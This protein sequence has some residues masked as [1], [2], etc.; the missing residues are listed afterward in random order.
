MYL[1][2]IA[3]A[4]FIPFMM[5]GQD[6]INIVSYNIRLDHEGDGKDQWKF[7]KEG[8]ASFLLEENADFIGLQEVLHHQLQ[9]LDSMLQGYTFIGVARDDGK[10][11]GEY[12]PLF[13]NNLEWR[14]IRQATNW[15]S[16]KPMEVSRGWDAACNRVVTYGVFEHLVSGEQ[17]TV[18]NT[19][20]DHMGVE[21]RK[22]S[23]ALVVEWAA[24]LSGSKYKVF[25]G[26]F[27]FTP[28]DEL[29]K[30]ITNK[31]FDAR[32]KAAVKEEVHPGTYNGFALT[33][34]YPR[35]IDYVFINEGLKPVK[36]Y[37]P[38]IRIDGRHISDH[39]PVIVELQY[40]E[41]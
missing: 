19:H 24:S 37:C 27:N 7:R 6:A 21:A 25:T 38:D 22:K 4:L 9:Y 10:T 40:K 31:L 13:Y 3:I 12:S 34:P 2:Y 30:I 14:L 16:E 18:F 33:G 1:K 20:F 11:A 39:F 32:T 35:R 26:D 8:L 28:D 29:Y 15:L 23:A 17:I 5:Q 41:D 36:Y